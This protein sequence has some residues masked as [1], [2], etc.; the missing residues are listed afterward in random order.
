MCIIDHW[1]IESVRKIC[2]FLTTKSIILTWV[3]FHFV[4]II[5][6]SNI[7]L[8]SL[9]SCPISSFQR[10]CFLDL[11]SSTNLFL[12][13]HCYDYRTLL[14]CPLPPSS[15]HSFFVFTF[16][17]ALQ[18]FCFIVLEF[19]KVFFAVFLYCQFLNHFLGSPLQ[20][21]ENIVFIKTIFMYP[22]LVKNDCFPVHVFILLSCTL[23]CFVL[24]NLLLVYLPPF[25][26]LCWYF[27][28]SFNVNIILSFIIQPSPR[29]YPI[30]LLL[31]S[32][33]INL[34]F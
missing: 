13:G 15:P 6:L 26:L 28:S 25:C 31:F 16:F 27:S 11:L 22:L 24:W 9:P 23:D 14:Q 19:L 32:V 5:L 18:S 33:S 20:K 29:S 21:L 2:H 4:F 3:W 17:L 12:L 7:F 8:C 30:P 34:S 10:T 1:N